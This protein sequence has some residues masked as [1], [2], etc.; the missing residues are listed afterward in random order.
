MAN[1]IN[2]AL[3]GEFTN[4][5]N[6]LERIHQEAKNPTSFFIRTKSG[7]VHIFPRN[8]NPETLTIDGE[9]MDEYR[10]DSKLF[11]NSESVKV[12]LKEL[13]PET[14][15]IVIREQG[16]TDTTKTRKLPKNIR[17]ILSISGDSVDKKEINTN[18]LDEEGKTITLEN[19]KEAEEVAETPRKRYERRAVI[20]DG[21]ELYINASAAIEH[22]P[23]FRWYREGKG[24]ER[25][26]RKD[27]DIFYKKCETD[28][29]FLG[30]FV[31]YATKEEIGK[32]IEELES[33]V[34]E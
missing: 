21:D 4:L 23:L 7:N 30:V 12:N 34:E 31:A 28:H 9:L 32:V 27:A 24:S 20:V 16:Y 26:P 25:D 33:K 18:L 17:G 10:R 14:T 8:F 2:R 13:D 5:F 3:V 11:I 6:D 29:N 22:M 1:S 15:K 19:W